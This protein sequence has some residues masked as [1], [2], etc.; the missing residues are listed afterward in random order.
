MVTGAVEALLIAAPRPLSS[1]EI[2]SVMGLESTLITAVI[3][4][5]RESWDARVAGMEL[6][7]TGQGWRVHTRRDFAPIVSQLLSAAPVGKLTAAALETLAIIS[8]LQPVT[9][10]RIASIRGVNVD[11]VV[12]SLL[13][14][15]LIAESGQGP[16]GPSMR[17]K[18][19][20]V[21]LD[22]IGLDSLDELPDLA[23]LLPDI[24]AVEE[25]DHLPLQLDQ[26]SSSAD[27]RDDTD[28]GSDLS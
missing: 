28:T 24:E 1:E 20:D 5:L 13:A 18:T 8:Y 11:G 3:S 26:S 19:T 14:R 6:V 27:T 17:Y 9:R 25:Y 23:P 2:A 15:G 10:S 22:R 4:E 12:R 21:F 7:L 16:D